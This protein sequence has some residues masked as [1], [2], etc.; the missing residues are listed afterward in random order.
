V[1]IGELQWVVAAYTLTF[2][3]VLLPGGALGD[4]LGH[5][6]TVLLG[7]LAFGLA[8]VA[9]GLAPNGAVLI[10][11]RAVQGVGAALLLPASLAVITHTFPDRRAQARAL[12]VWAGVSSLALPAGPV[13]GGLLVTAAGWRAVFWINLPIIAVAAILTMR[14]TGDTR[15]VR[16]YRGL[17]VLNR[18]FVGANAVALCMNFVGIGTIF[19]AT[20]YLQDVR[21]H[22]ALVGGLALLPL[23]TPLAVL[24][25]ITGRLTARFG[26]RWPMAAGLA[27]GAA[28]SAFLGVLVQPAFVALGI[29]MGLLT[30][31][32]VAAAMAAAPPERSGLAAG[33]NN[34]ARQAGGALGTVVYGAIAGD[35]ADPGRFVAGMHTA[36]LVGA[37]VWLAALVVTLVTVRG[38]AGAPRDADHSSASPQH[39]RSMM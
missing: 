30:A 5:R 11:A 38:R 18:Q 1:S 8:S 3:L 31:A 26:P 35:P 27:L 37:G 34:T 2:A 13:L 32:V 24:S 12:G 20:L 4:R 28:A 25:P 39:A 10:G 23:F 36:G 22:S 7:M 14:I 9:G 16:R 19:V 6:P 15:Q 29:G 21:H 17:A 33:V